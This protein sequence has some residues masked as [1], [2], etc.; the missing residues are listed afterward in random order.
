MNLFFDTE[1][2]GLRRNTTLISIGIVS[3]NGKKFYA[4]FADYNRSQCDKWIKKNVIC[5]LFLRQFP[6]H[7]KFHP[8]FSKIIVDGEKYELI[9]S[10]IYEMNGILEYSWR[11]IDGETTYVYGDFCSISEALGEWLSQFD[12]IQFISDVCHYHYVCY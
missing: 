11:K 2:T 6:I 3:E 5:N 12:S 10:G 9:D 1:F 7:R 8:N 4:E